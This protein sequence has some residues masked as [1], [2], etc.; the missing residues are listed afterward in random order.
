MPC[1]F[2]GIFLIKDI[3]NG[4]LICSFNQDVAESDPDIRDITISYW[5][6]GNTPTPLPSAYQIA[7]ANCIYFITGTLAVVDKQELQPVVLLQF[8]SVPSNI[9]RS[10]ASYHDLYIVSCKSGTR[11]FVANPF[12]SYCNSQNDYSPDYP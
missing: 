8:L 6:P 7:E 9:L 11:Q 2:S 1:H 12:I 5:Q 3:A 4:K 10:D